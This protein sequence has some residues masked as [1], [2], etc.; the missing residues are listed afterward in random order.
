MNKLLDSYLVYNKELTNLNIE[1]TGGYSYQ[2]YEVESYSSQNIIDPTHISDI[3]T[4]TDVVNIGFFARTNL[5]FYDKY[6]LTLSP[7]E[8]C[9]FCQELGDYAY[10][11]KYNSVINEWK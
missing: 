8:I 1:V 2:K 7:F 11:Q 5:N 10:A 6:L 3:D 4:A 9:K